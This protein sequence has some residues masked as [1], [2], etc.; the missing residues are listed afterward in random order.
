M[1]LVRRPE[2]EMQE[3]RDQAK[4]K[5]EAERANKRTEA[6]RVRS[7]EVPRLHPLGEQG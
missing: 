4:A 6:Q 5:A 3:R 2:G 1:M 7:Y